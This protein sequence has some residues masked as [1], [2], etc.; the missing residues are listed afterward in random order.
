MRALTLLALAAV[1]LATVDA[2]GKTFI[3][4]LTQ[5]V[6]SGHE[7]G[8]LRKAQKLDT[9]VGRRGSKL[10]QRQ[11]KSEFFSGNC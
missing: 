11:Y 8:Q 7:I 10:I 3:I 2:A 4:P 1:L 6:L 9:G 5:R